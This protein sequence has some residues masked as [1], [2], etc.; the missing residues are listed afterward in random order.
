MRNVDEGKV[1]AHAGTA[2]A[3]LDFSNVLGALPLPL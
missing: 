2:G 1:R 3:M